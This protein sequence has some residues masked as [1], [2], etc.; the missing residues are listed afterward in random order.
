M[1]YVAIFSSNKSGCEFALKL[2]LRSYLEAEP[3]TG[4][5]FSGI[6]P[7]QWFSYGAWVMVAS[8][9][10]AGKRIFELPYEFCLCV[11]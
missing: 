7:L 2:C 10:F 5:S 3:E 9:I 8:G 6:S 1:L 4:L 11:Y